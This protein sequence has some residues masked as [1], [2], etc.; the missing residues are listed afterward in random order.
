MEYKTYILFLISLM[1]FMAYSINT[2]EFAF[3]Y[4]ESNRVSYTGPRADY[5]PFN[6]YF[7]MVSR[8]EGIVMQ[9]DACDE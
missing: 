1:V 2:C 4:P 7:Y 9:F 6:D 5:D 3:S 8:K